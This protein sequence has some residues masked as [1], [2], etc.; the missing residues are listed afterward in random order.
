M[1]IIVENIRCS[2]KY[3]DGRTSDI[4]DS[5]VADER[6]RG[7]TENSRFAVIFYAAVLTV[8]GIFDDAMTQNTS[9]RC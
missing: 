3:L 9:A 4:S 6:R 7:N 1:N 2:A 8:S 5:I